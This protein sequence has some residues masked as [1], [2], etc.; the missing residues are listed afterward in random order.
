MF[1][2]YLF[3]PFGDI[4]WLNNCPKQFRYVDDIFVLFESEDHI[5]KFEKYL[6]SRHNNMK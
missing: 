6:N 1:E 3:R 2:L 4:Y 5:K